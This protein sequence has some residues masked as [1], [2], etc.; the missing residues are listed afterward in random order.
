M[1]TAHVRDERHYS[2]ESRA[3]QEAQAHANAHQSPVGVWQLGQRMPWFAASDVAP[4]LMEPDPEACGYRLIAV[5]D[6]S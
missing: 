2:L 6:P 3:L 1:T 4:D 5:V